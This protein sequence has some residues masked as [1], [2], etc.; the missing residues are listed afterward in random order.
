MSDRTTGLVALGV[1]AALAGIA[2]GA[3]GGTELTRTS[4]VEVLTV[5]AAGVVVAAGVVWGRRGPLYGATALFLFA[6]LAFVTALSVTWAVVPE[7]AYIEAGR[8][9]AYL[10]IFAAG[11]AGAR[12]AIHAAPAVIQGILIAALAAVAYALL[13][14]VW[15][16]TL[17]EDELSNRLG[18]PFQY[19]NALGTTAALAIPGLLWLGTRR[20][21]G[22]VSRALAYPGVGAAILAI[23]LSQSRGA[24]AAAAIGVV[25][26][27]V[28]VP[29]RLRSLPVILVPAAFAAAVGAWALSKDAFSA[30][31]PSLAVKEDVGTEFGLLL[32][33]LVAGLFAAGFAVNIALD[34]GLVPAGMRK[35]AG[36]L[37]VG[38]A[39]LVALMALA[40][41]ALSE[42]G[43]TGTIDDRF[44]ELT[45]ETD[46]A[47][48]GSGAARFGAASSTRGK[49]W[50]EARLVFEERPSVGTGAG[51][52]R[53]ARLRHRTDPSVTGH[54]HGFVPQTLADLGLVGL[55]VTTLLLVAWLIAAA[56][57]IAL[58][59]RRLP[60]GR[61]RGE[62]PGPREW[63]AE[64]VALVALVLIALVFGLQSAIDW[65]WFVPGP[66]AM[67]L[68][69]AG[70]V[71]GR[72]PL[73]AT[74]EREEVLGVRER[75]AERSPARLVAAGAVLLAA[76]LAAWTI[77]QPEAGD[78]A[79][80]D[81]LT[82]LDEG[83][84]E[85]ALT[86]TEDARSADPLSAEP[87]LV[88]ASVETQANRESDAR[89]TLEEAVL[90][91]PGSVDTWYRLAAFQLGTLDRPLRAAQTIQGALYLDPLSTPA[92]QLFLDARARARAK[93]IEAAKARQRRSRD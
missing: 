56:R 88:R 38:V 93:A 76:V 58:V 40:S 82:L 23:L 5:L 41:V 69:A 52:F 53:V 73:A 55:A 84:F 72:G 21:A 63:T 8:T 86:K 47:P 80:G 64:R 35:H 75:M 49:Y 78:R 24:L 90:K 31:A 12:L 81:A 89:D 45:S 11:V 2:F 14:R 26:W 54:A 13:S 39:G 16:G 15:P 1:G 43:L 59:P 92:R 77:W 67:A 65:T 37:A 10:A 46:T 18:Q 32:F 6:L 22:V 36:V 29:L 28:V 68:L 17:A 57:T 20:A 30:S 7:L 50:K 27:L 48:T 66:T 4:V 87:L 79:T 19:W 60:W 9:L 61:E 3:A 83:D 74:G 91:F 85:A 51:T 25:L 33:L 70:F 62:P 42:R 71:A 34:R 44:D